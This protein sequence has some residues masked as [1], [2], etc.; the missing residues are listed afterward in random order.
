VTNGDALLGENSGYGGDGDEHA[1]DGGFWVFPD[2]GDGFHVLAPG[3]AEMMSPILRPFRTAPLRRPN[4]VSSAK[5]GDLRAK[6]GFFRA[7]TVT[8][9]PK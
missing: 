3:L 5:F 1:R 4:E 8:S 9:R 7:E 6:T 2:I